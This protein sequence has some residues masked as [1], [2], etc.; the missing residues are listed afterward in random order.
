MHLN[1]QNIK[2]EIIA[3][4]LLL[5]ISLLKE[6]MRLEIN[7]NKF[8]EDNSHKHELFHQWVDNVH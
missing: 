5:L 1:V 3:T 2:Q 6:E 4:L 8:L 7:L